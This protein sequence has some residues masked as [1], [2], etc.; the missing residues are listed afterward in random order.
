MPVEAV[1][2]G[3]TDWQLHLPRG[4]EIVEMPLKAGGDGGEE[5]GEREQQQNDQRMITCGEAL[6]G[7]RV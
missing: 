5:S 1:G 3:A 2:Q 6:A 4:C 7:Q